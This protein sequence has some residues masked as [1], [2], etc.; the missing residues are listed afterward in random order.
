VRRSVGRR[1]QAALD[2]AALQ[3]EHDQ[4]V[5]LELVVGDAARLDGDHATLGVQ[6]RDV[7]ERVNRQ[8]PLRDL[9]VRDPGSLFEL[10]IR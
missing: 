1:S 2:D 9:L 3:I 4:V 5:Y 10:S 6:R 7:T 8:A